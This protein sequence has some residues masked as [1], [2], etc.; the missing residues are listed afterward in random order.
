MEPV[1]YQLSTST[2]NQAFLMEVSWEC[3]LNIGM[4]GGKQC[5]GYE[6]KSTSIRRCLLNLLVP[7]FTSTER[8]IPKI[9]S[10][11]VSR[12]FNS[13]LTVEYN[14]R[15]YSKYLRLWFVSHL[16]ILLRALSFVIEFGSICW[17]RLL[18]LKQSNNSME[19]RFR[20]YLLSRELTAL[21]S[22]PSRLSATV[23]KCLRLLI[24]Y[25]SWSSIELVCRVFAL[26]FTNEIVSFSGQTFLLL[27]NN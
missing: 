27:P 2:G 26:I 23:W 21:Y 19:Y 6:Q 9:K 7:C 14:G 24:E 25:K 12:Q 15:E 4:V 18:Q 20:Y 5:V 13:C 17:I 16:V 8:R 10:T 11:G 1:L 3:K 22:F